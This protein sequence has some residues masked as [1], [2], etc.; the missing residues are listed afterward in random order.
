MSTPTSTPPAAPISAPISADMSQIEQAL[1]RVSYLASRFRQHDRLMAMAG[2][3][4]DRAAVALLRQIADT[5][6]MRP[7]ALAG[8]LGVEASHITRQVQQLEKGGYVTRIPD[9][10]DRRAQR[11]E[12][13]PTGEDVIW[14]IREA[15]CRGM[16]IALADWSPDE[17]HQLAT[18]FHRMVGDFL[19]HSGEEEAGSA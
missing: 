2:V 19:T 7:S 15:S 3:S 11:I 4:L 12:I 10:A 1:T 16:Q 9:P 14:R 17:L 13:T 5:E 6:P 8:L 18:L